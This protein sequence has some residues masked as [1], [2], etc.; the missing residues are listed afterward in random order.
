MKA[1]G[2]ISIAFVET[3]RFGYMWEVLAYNFNG[4]EI[5][6]RFDTE[7]EAIKFANSIKGENSYVD[8][9]R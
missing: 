6:E 2:R 7:K 5:G 3:A 9:T 1:F 8:N 4:E